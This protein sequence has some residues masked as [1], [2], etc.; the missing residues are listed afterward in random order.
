MSVIDITTKAGKMLAKKY[1]VTTS[2]LYIN[3][4]TDGTECRNDMTRL[5]LSQA[6]DSP[7]EFKQQIRSKVEYL[8]YS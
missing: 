2:S 1:G 3:K 7:E 8:L 5:G 6:S 4:W